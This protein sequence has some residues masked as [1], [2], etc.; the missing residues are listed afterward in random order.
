MN[1]PKPRSLPDVAI[2]FAVVLGVLALLVGAL[3]LTAGDGDVLAFNYG[4]F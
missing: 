3:I 1:V 4:G 2:A